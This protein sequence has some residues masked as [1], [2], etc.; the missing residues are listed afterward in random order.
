MPLSVKDALG[1]RGG[2]GRWLLG[3]AGLWCGPLLCRAWL[4]YL[5]ESSCDVC[6][7]EELGARPVMMPMMS[8]DAACPEAN[9]RDMVLPPEVFK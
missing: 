8:G 3:K 7:G 4:F 2:G 6:V 9:D 1:V 5:P